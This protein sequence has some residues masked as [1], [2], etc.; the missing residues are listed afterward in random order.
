M[1]FEFSLLEMF[2]VFCASISFL[3]VSDLIVN[4]I[5]DNREESNQ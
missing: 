4:V 5:R 3:A 2:I 1:Q